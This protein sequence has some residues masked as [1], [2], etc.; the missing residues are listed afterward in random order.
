[1][2]WNWEQPNWPN[3]TWDKDRLE[4]AEHRFLL[5]SGIFLGTVKHLDG[6]ER[7]QLMI[8]SMSS[9]ALTTSEIEGE[10]LDRASVQSSIRRQLGLG[11]DTHRVPPAEQGIAELMVSLYRTYAEPLSD[12]TLF[13]WHGMLLNG[14]QDLRDV[15][16]YRTQ[17]EPM[18][19]ISGNIHEPKV[20]FEAPPH[21]RLPEEMARF[22]DWFNRTAP[23]GPTPLPVLTRAG[24][25][26][27]YFVS[28]HPFEDG[29]GRIGRAI[30]EKALAQ[31]AGQP[32]FTTLSSTIL[33]KRK[34]YY[35]ALEA[36]S[37][38]NEITRWLCWFADIA[39]EAQQRTI[40]Q[41]DFLIAKTRLFD[42]LHGQLNSRQERALLRM[43]R[44]GP[45][46]FKGGLS[47]GNYMRITDTTTA[48][49]TRD[50]ADLVD[51][52]ALIRAGEHRYARYNLNVGK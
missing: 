34:E 32:T 46:G 51:K 4:S 40:A 27:L 12:E 3:F 24:I 10:I 44:E 19:V 48:T 6:K 38:K 22:I 20:H 1:M 47:A 33:T 52:G 42:R 23:K 21:W 18:Q 14:R 37:R 25:A 26:H 7:D 2:G 29:N 11:T 8:E 41:I 36:A 13:A 43:F 17:S 45:D 35:E 39:D 31:S 15:G 9:E 5:D 49:A 50:L 28:V 30:S 16:R